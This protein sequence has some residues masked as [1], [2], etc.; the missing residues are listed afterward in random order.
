MSTPT[1]Q[2]PNPKALYKRPEQYYH[3]NA[4]SWFADVEYP[5]PSKPVK[6]AKVARMRTRKKRQPKGVIRFRKMRPAERELVF[7]LIVIL[8]IYK[9]TA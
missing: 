5:N 7:W 6:P 4:G 2:P 8:I 9:L 3:T 1:Y